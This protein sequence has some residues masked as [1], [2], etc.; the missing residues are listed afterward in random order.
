MAARQST[1]IVTAM[2][3][4]WSFVLTTVDGLK[5]NS[6]DWLELVNF[7]Y[8]A[9]LFVIDLSTIVNGLMHI[10]HVLRMK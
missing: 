6:K 4:A 3:S 2:V 9:S 10:L 7:Y 1:V 5:L 8:S